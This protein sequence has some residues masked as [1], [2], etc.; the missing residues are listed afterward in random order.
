MPNDLFHN[1]KVGVVT[2]VLVIKAHQPHP[3]NKET[4]LGYW[5]NDGFVKKKLKGRID[6][7]DKWRDI[8]SEWL[9]SY[10][11][12]KETEGFSLNRYL[13]ANEEWCIEAYMKTDYSKLSEA[14]YMRYVKNYVLFKINES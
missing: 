14:D 11:N 9:K 13:A 1:S 8:K 3:K 7:Y 5:K 2:A 12:K 6:F 10:A 4:Y